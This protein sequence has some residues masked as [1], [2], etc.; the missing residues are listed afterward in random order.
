MADEPTR[1]AQARALLAQL[2]DDGGRR[3]RRVLAALPFALTVGVAAGAVA[4]D[5][6]GMSP[7]AAG[8]ALA[9]AFAVLL[10]MATLLE[11]LTLALLQAAR[12]EELATG[13]EL[14]WDLA[15]GAVLGRLVAPLL[16]TSTVAAVATFA[17][18][19][20]VYQAVVERVVLGEMADGLAALLWP[21]SG[22]RPPGEHSRAGALAARGEHELALAEY[23][24]AVAR[25]PRDARPYLAV[26]RLLRD[27]LRQPEEAAAWLRRALDEARPPPSVEVH[28][29]RE[30]AELLMRAGGLP[31]AAPELARIAHRFGHTEAGAWARRELAAAKD[32]LRQRLEQAEAAAALDVPRGGDPVPD[33]P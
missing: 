33:A 29:R 6:L 11:T 17:G 1:R 28:V 4:A 14:G 15:I 2:A 3:R 30:L 5:D 23:R 19:Y 32:E 21:Q 18:F 7:S 25:Q 24:A 22:I 20:A 9:A 26:A 31:R 16:D 12:T 8:L 10:W 13:V 27:E